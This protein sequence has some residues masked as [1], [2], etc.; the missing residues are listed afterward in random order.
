MN[1]Q[2]FHQYMLN[3][4]RGDL[5]SPDI[6]AVSSGLGP[7]LSMNMDRPVDLHAPA[8]PTRNTKRVRSPSPI[9]Y[10]V[11]KIVGHG[12]KAV[13]TMYYCLFSDLNSIFISG[14][15]TLACQMV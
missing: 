6:S 4:H 3:H 2:I 15:E 8:R 7:N 10:Q 13:S 1:R 5:Q 9:E 11:E 12:I 14:Q